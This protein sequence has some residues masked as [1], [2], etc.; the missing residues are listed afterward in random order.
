MQQTIALKTTKMI[1]YKEDGVGWMI[2]NNP[3][4]LNALGVEMNQAIPEILGDFAQDPEVRV[5]VMTGAGDRA[6]VSGADISEF[7]ARR[8]SPEQIEEYNRIGSRANEAY[9]ALGKP[10]IAM[11]RGY[12]IGGGLLTAM[13]ADLRICTEESQFGIPAVRL[14]LGY[15]YDNVKAMVDLIGPAQ[16]RYILITGSRIDA[17][18][19]LR[20]GL[21]NRVVPAAELESSVKELASIIAANAP[22]TVKAVRAAVEEAVKDKDDRDVE[23]ADQLA[24]DCMASEDYIEGRRA[25]MEKRRP[26]FKGR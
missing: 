4:R 18:T 2:F 8:A 11:I 25:F 20:M 1:A 16:T 7:E 21:V 9:H 6:F 12:A 3:D 26:A 15:G 10:L 22:L 24:A 13:K 5:A 14:G 17:Q 23:R 19:A